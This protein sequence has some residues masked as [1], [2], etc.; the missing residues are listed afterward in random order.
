MQNLLKEKPNLSERGAPKDGQPQSSDHRLF[1]QLQAYTGCGDWRAVADHMAAAGVPGALYLDFNDPLGIAILSWSDKPDYFVEE[2]RRL[3]RT[4]PISALKPRP[5][6][7]MAGRS[8][9]LGYEADLREALFDRLIRTATNPAWPWAVWYPLRRHG[10][11]EKLDEQAQRTVLMEHGQ[12]GRSFAEGDYAHD[13]RLA[14]H[15]LDRNDNDFLIGL[16]GKELH[17]LSAIVATMRKTQQ[18]ST[19]IQNLGP[20]FVGKVVWQSTGNYSPPI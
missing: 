13:I 19:Y 11:F 10:E 9:S 3:Q 17:P 2:F 20:F 16:I 14:C 4:G 1:M 7:A 8:Y 12:I 15:G 5:E 6:F 18:T